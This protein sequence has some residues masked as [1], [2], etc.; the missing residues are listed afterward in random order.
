MKFLRRNWLIPV[1]ALVAF[2]ALA[3]VASAC[4]SCKAALS[5]S[6]E[7]QKLVR[8]YFWSICFMVAMPFTVF[9]GMSGY[10]Y[11]LVRNA[12]RNGPNRPL[13]AMAAPANVDQE[14]PVG[15]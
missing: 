14:E 15:V 1:V 6:T 10:L 8:G 11:W 9:G 13:D 5:E 7:G 12:K 4:P 2:C 3:T